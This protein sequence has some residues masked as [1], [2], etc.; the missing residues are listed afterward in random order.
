[1]KKIFI[2]GY[3]GFG[4]IGDEAI[5]LSL[6]DWI[7]Q[8]V[9]GVEIVITSSNI[10]RSELDT[11]VRGVEIGRMSAVLNEIY[12]CE[13][14]I[15][16][17]GGCFNEYSE[18]DSASLQNGR[19]DYN[20]LCAMVSEVAFSLNRRVFVCGVGV[21]P[22]Q[23]AKAHTSV[24][25]ALSYADVATLR[26]FESLDSLGITDFNNDLIHV[27]ACPALCLDFKLGT[28]NDP[29]YGERMVIG[30][31]LRYWNYQNLFKTDEHPGWERTI[32]DELKSIAGKFDCQFL[33]IPF[34]AEADKGELADD[35]PVI[36]RVI[37]FAGIKGRSTIADEGNPREILSLISQCDLMIVCRYHSAIFAISA[38]V[39]FVTLSY[40]RKVS[41]A[42]RMA[43]LDNYVIDLSKIEV[44]QL[45]NSVSEILSKIDE[46]RTDLGTLTDS[47]KLA[48]NENFLIIEKLLTSVTPPT[49]REEGIFAC[50]MSLY[51]R[52]ENQLEFVENTERIVKNLVDLIQDRSL[53]EDT[54]KLIA[55]LP[56]EVRE[57]PQV[58]YL[59]ALTAHAS[60]SE[61]L[62]TR[63]L[64]LDSLKAGAAKFWVLYN[65]GFLEIHNKRYLKA[66]HSW[67]KAIK[68]E[69][70]SLEHKR[71]IEN[72]L[73]SQFRGLLFAMIWRITR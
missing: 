6:L 8:H 53:S 61:Y 41:S 35:I 21:E 13:L 45:V 31:S 19:P 72:E 32:A 14:V 30:V 39:P 52:N 50:L 48:S 24:V 68:L 28:K 73:R 3:F 10:E 43:G 33:F 56:M 44:G 47:L 17:G 22:L 40:S 70:S 7:E 18:W 2:V 29:I 27:T 60:G 51:L 34:Q 38:Q 63:N 23:S 12:N 37:H 16:A 11:R 4:Q 62:F 9:P 20:V 65:L 54:H 69:P 71:S 49:K 58:K 5:L 42:A 66:I 1:V 36:K 55:S 57:H 64:Y 67:R 25:R 46:V 59:F 26:D 15:I